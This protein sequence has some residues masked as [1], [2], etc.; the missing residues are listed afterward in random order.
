MTASFRLTSKFSS[1]NFPKNADNIEYLKNLVSG[2][3]SE[4]NGFLRI[5]RI[6][7]SNVISRKKYAFFFTESLY[8]IDKFNVIFN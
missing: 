8:K 4:L 5:M 1:Q 6:G 2:S 7:L 3:F